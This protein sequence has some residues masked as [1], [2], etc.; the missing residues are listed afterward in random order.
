MPG[1]GPAGRT[2]RVHARHAP[3]GRLDELPRPPGPGLLDLPP[4]PG[5]GHVPGGALGPYACGLPGG[6]PPPP[7]RPHPLAGVHLPHHVGS[8]DPSA[9]GSGVTAPCGALLA[10][11]CI[12]AGR[13]VPRAP[14][15]CPLPAEPAPSGGTPAWEGERFQGRGELRDQPTTGEGPGTGDGLPSGAWGTRKA[16]SW[17]G[18]KARPARSYCG[19]GAASTRSSR[20]AAS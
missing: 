3:V 2:D 5:C 19:N 18:G 17:S 20:T 9:G 14:D 8:Q 16:S 7:H 13:A 6:P 4:L 12:V 15:G 10:C 11:G 1:G